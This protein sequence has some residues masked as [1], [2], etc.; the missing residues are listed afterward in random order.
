MQVRN[1]T[2]AP[3]MLNARTNAGKVT[4]FVTETG[5]EVTKPETPQTA[6]IAIPAEATVEIDDKLWIQAT[7]GKTTVREMKEVTEVIPG[8]II[9]KKPVYRTFNEPTGVTREVNL[10]AE[11]VRI[12]DLT[13]VEKVK[14]EVTLAQMIKALSDK[15]LTVSKETH[16]EA[17]IAGLYETLCA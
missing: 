3:I 17:E 10:I 9:D 11:R 14:S 5:V 13:I 8:A 7:S 12:G 16:T 4:K 1:N 15:K 2:Q 6:L